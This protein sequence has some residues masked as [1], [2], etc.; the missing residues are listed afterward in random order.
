MRVGILLTL[1]VHEL[2]VPRKSAV[3]AP[4]LVA[5]HA[6]LA[7]TDDWSPLGLV[8]VE[9]GDRRRVSHGQYLMALWIAHV[10]VPRR[11]VHG[12]VVAISNLRHAM[13]Q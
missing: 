2:G 4:V 5:W 13:E 3:P 7:G 12:N 8:R 9:R 10:Q 6:P 1:G 11:R